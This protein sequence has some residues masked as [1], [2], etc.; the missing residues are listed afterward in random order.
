MVYALLRL[1]TVVQPKIKLLRD[2][3]GNELRTYV[4]I[5]HRKGQW[6]NVIPEKLISDWLERGY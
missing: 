3:A 5:F 2:A 4:L 6:R 1:P